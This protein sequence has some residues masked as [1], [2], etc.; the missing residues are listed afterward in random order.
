MSASGLG[1]SGGLRVLVTGASGL[2]GCNAALSWLG[3]FEVVP[4]YGSRSVDLPGAFALDLGASGASDVL[5][6]TYPDVI[7]HC[8]AATDV[9]RCEREPEW[10]RRANV[11]ATRAAAEAARDSGARLIHISTDAVFDGRTGGYSEDDAP[12]PVNEYARTKLEAEGVALET[13][14]KCLVVRTNIFGWSPVAGRG[15]AEWLFRQLSDG[16]KVTGFA[17]TFFSPV[18]VND[19]AVLLRVLVTNP[20]TGILHVA[21]R[22]RMSKYDFARRLATACDLDAELIAQGSMA[23]AMLAT[24]RPRDTSLDC[25]RAERL[26]LRL[27]GID[28]ALSEFASLGSS[29]WSQRLRS[30]AKGDDDA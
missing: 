22:D 17:D 21:G 4:T 20:A 9:G 18:L 23:D 11:D 8:A 26:G 13:A 1:S 19:L 24:P 16:C 5:A 30:L 7:V 6:A 25:T 15:L 3:D 2:L 29:G 28:S 27:P 12:R 10:A 14:Q